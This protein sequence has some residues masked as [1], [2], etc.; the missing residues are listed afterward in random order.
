MY[1]RVILLGNL[2]RHVELKRSA[3]GHI[4]AN[5]GIAISRNFI[6]NGEN[7]EEVCH[8][9][10]A[11]YGRTAEVANQYLRQGSKLMVIGYLQFLQC[12]DQ[13]N[14]LKLSKHIIVV[15]NIQLHDNKKIYPHAPGITDSPQQFDVNAYDKI[16]NDEGLVVFTQSNIY[17]KSCFNNGAK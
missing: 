9:D 4:I 6:H 8:I 15:E 13:V 12:V 7:K 14:G 2:T 11:I 10:L 16:R 5:T 1:N 17:E 3:N